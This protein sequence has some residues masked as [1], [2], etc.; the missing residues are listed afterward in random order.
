MAS[1]DMKPFSKAGS[2]FLPLVLFSCALFLQAAEEK[3]AAANKPLPSS[4]DVLERYT[5]AIGGKEA[6][7]KHKSQRAIGTIE[8]SAQQAKGKMEAHAARPNKLLMKTML[9]GVGEISTGFDGK[10]AW[11]KTAL[12]GSMLLEGKMREEVARDA[13]F[14][15]ALRDPAD[16]KTME[17]LGIEEFNGEECYKLHL[18]HR[19]GFDS[20]E[21][22]STKTG[23]QRGHVAT[24]ETP[25]GAVKATT[26]ITDYNQFGNLFLPSRIAQ[27]AMG[28]EMVT[29]IDRMEFDNVDPAIFELP[30]D[31][32]A[33]LEE[34]ADEKKPGTPRAES[35]TEAQE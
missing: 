28:M 16:Y 12:T 35:K 21:Y 6:F 5:K 1:V 27:T 19:T 24:E 23:L 14:D 9:P 34:P 8:M 3:P 17:V 15:K 4:K 18:V 10:T 30:A 2:F 22:F 20:I 31:V 26:L 7:M 29:S 32:K 11:M 25:F 33:L 13:E